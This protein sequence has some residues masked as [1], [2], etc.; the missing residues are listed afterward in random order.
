MKRCYVVFFTILI[1]FSTVFS[2][3]NASNTFSF[4]SLTGQDSNSS[5]ENKNSDS[6]DSQKSS[7]AE[8]DEA[9]LMLQPGYIPGSNVH[10]QIVSVENDTDYSEFKIFYG[11]GVSRGL[12]FP[13]TTF[14]FDDPLDMTQ[15]NATVQ[16]LCSKGSYLSIFVQ[17]EGRA[18]GEA[19]DGYDGPY[20]LSMWLGYPQVNEQEKVS[21]RYEVAAGKVG[22]IGLK[23]GSKGECQVVALQDV[24]L[25]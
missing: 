24:K 6:A 18:S 25:L 15:Q 14:T 13:Q 10:L 17:D 19:D 3:D 23:I 4:T 9:G 12:L 20:Y 7:Y 2:T 11:A 1:G 22:K 21:I 8:A 5:L 16:L